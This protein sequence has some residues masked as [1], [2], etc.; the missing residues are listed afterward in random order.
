MQTPVYIFPGKFSEYSFAEGIFQRSK[1]DN[2]KHLLFRNNRPEK[3]SARHEILNLDRFDVPVHVFTESRRYSRISL[4]EK[5]IH[6]RVPAGMGTHQRQKEIQKLLDWAEGRLEK[7][8]IYHPE[9]ISRDY[10]NLD[11]IPVWNDV[12]NVKYSKE[13]GPRV[14]RLR[15]I[16]AENTIEIKGSWQAGEEEQARSAVRKGLLRLVTK[17]YKEEVSKRVDEV[18][19]KTIRGDYKNVR[20]KYVRSRWGS[21]SAKG[22]ITISTRLLFAPEPVRDYVILHELAHLREMNHSRK[23]W[24]IVARYVPDYKKHTKWLKENGH[25]CDL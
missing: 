5:K 22:D 12:W 4:L 25:L 9:V 11:Q 7:K 23:F 14:V 2:P 19:R 10:L 3:K 18:N 20:M 21:C 8:N 6:I 15:M 13:S 16:E 1:I 24:D 17:R